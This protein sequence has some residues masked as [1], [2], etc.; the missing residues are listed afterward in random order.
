MEPR[1][2]VARQ[3]IPCAQRVLLVEVCRS[4]SGS[5]RHL[6]GCT[7]QGLSLSARQACAVARSVG[8]LVPEPCLRQTRLHDTAKHERGSLD[9]VRPRSDEPAMHVEDLFR[10]VEDPG[11]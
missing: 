4:S 10:L 9:D 6:N 2:R 8:N 11:R 7:H 5:V 3:D 1:A